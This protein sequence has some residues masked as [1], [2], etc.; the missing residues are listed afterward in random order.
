MTVKFVIGNKCSVIFAASCI[1]MLIVTQQVVHQ[2]VNGSC[3]CKLI[4]NY[5]CIMLSHPSVIGYEKLFTRK[6]RNAIV[7]CDTAKTLDM[8]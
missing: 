8:N 1:N 4:H 2:L 7:R 5:P 3:D 6:G